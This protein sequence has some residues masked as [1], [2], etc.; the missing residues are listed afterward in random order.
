MSKPVSQSVSRSV[1]ARSDSVTHSLTDSLAAAPRPLVIAVHGILTRMT[2]ANW[3]DELWAAWSQ[4]STLCVLK[5]EYIGAPLPAWNKWVKNFIVARGLVAEVEAYVNAHGLGRISFVAHSNGCDIVVKTVKRL[6]R[7]GIPTDTIILT[8]SVT[9]L[10]VEASG[11][12]DLMRRGMLRRAVAYCSEK[13]RAIGLHIK[14]PYRNLG[15]TGWK[16]AGVMLS[17]PRV[18][19]HDVRAFL[20]GEFVTRRFDNFDHGDYF[21]DLHRNTTF[22]LFR[23]DLGL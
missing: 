13:D 16:S 14:W 18:H 8:G 1:A 5:K 12:A 21:D 10:D 6:A 20:H 22:G 3:P 23:K 11:L 4:D 9:E 17:V 2:A 19:T 7:K 15:I